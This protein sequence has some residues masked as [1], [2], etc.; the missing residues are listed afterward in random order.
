MARQFP[1]WDKPI[2][3]HVWKASEEEIDMKL[4]FLGIIGGPMSRYNDNSEDDKVQRSDSTTSLPTWCNE[5]PDADNASLC[6][7]SISSFHCESERTCFPDSRQEEQDW[8]RNG[9]ANNRDPCF[10][11]FSEEETTPPYSNCSGLLSSFTFEDISISGMDADR[12][13]ISATASMLTLPT[14]VIYGQ[15]LVG[16]VVSMQQDRILP[17]SISWTIQAFYT[18]D[19]ELCFKLQ[20]VDGG[21]VSMILM[22]NEIIESVK[23]L[24]EKEQENQAYIGNFEQFEIIS[25]DNQSELVQTSNVLNH[26]RA[27]IKSSSYNATTFPLRQKIERFDNDLCNRQKNA[28]LNSNSRR[29]QRQESHTSAETNNKKRKIETRNPPS[30]LHGEY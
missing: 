14:D 23:L 10:E 24:V 4:P 20:M 21:G 15:D 3:P 11:S 6:L 9:E 30:V 7:R 17:P 2:F 12:R 8:L 18:S 19:Q 13:P 27:I 5:K 26:V 29:R 16:E 1:S 25:I 28:S 22:E